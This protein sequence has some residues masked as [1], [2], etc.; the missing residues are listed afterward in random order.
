M[1][2]HVVF[3]AL[4]LICL[5]CSAAD[6]VTQPSGQSPVISPEIPV[7]LSFAGE[8]VPLQRADV[9]ESYERELIVNTYLHSNTVQCI[10]R[11]A[12]FFPVIEPILA[13][14][15]I[16]DDF[17]YLCVIESDLIQKVS[18]AGAAGFW[19]IMRSTAVEG[20][21]EVNDEVDERYDLE[22]ATRFACTYFRTAYEQFG[23]WTMAAA[24]YNM[25]R[26]GAAKQVGLQQTARYYDLLLNDET[27]RYVY[28]ILAIKTIFEHPERYGFLIADDE[29]YAPIPCREIEVRSS[30]GDLVQ[31][32][33]DHQINYKILKWLNPWLRDSRLTVRSGKHYRIKLP[34]K[35]MHSLFSTDADVR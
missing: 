8:P 9:F 30:I 25:G 34:K 28:R 4:C 16:P 20:G 1:R 12:R 23:S 17:K 22:K 32:A 13:E 31:F 2:I 18:P 19:Q 11:S 3:S 15:N 6:P 14:N 35:G 27:A 21:M 7:S 5:A 29:K 24:A 26:N 10:K 33:I